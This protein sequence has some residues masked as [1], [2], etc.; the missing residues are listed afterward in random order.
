MRTTR[1]TEIVFERDRTIV[2][3]GR[4]PQR[5]AWCNQCQADVVMITVFDAA[6]LAGV[7][8]YTIHSEVASGDIHGFTTPEGI[9]L[10]CLNSLSA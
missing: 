7:S 4:Y 5:T 3:A 8:S 2:F 10:V 9:S 1:R 6:R